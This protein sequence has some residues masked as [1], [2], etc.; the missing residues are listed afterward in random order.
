MEIESLTD[1]W[2]TL[3]TKCLELINSRLVGHCFPS[4][5][6]EARRHCMRVSYIA[7]RASKRC[8]S[9]ALVSNSAI[10]IHTRLTESW[11]IT[12]YK[13]PTHSLSKRLIRH[14]TAT[15]MVTSFSFQFGFM[16][17]PFVKKNRTVFERGV[18]LENVFRGYK[19]MTMATTNVIL[20]RHLYE[21]ARQN[22]LT[23]RCWL[24]NESLARVNSAWRWDIR[25]RP[26]AVLYQRQKWIVQLGI[27]LPWSF[28]NCSNGLAST[29]PRRATKRK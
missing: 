13:R 18:E 25:R 22:I 29:S 4:L 27:K 8:T 20:C 11:E 16:V 19:L 3:V 6:S 28:I 12:R 14:P 15:E 23:E 26:L 10:F 21:H 2:L 9:P 5:P 24:P 1:N 7:M 17:N